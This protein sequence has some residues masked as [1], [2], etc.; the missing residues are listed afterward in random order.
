MGEKMKDLIKEYLEK[1]LN[2]I[3]IGYRLPGEIN[4]DQFWENLQ[5]AREQGAERIA[6]KDQKG[7]GF[8]FNVPHSL[9]RKLHEIDS[10]GRDTLFS[11][12]KAEI[13]SEM[14]KES[15]IE[16]ALNSSVIEGAFSTLKRA[17]ELA[18][19]NENPKDNSEQMIL[20]NFYAMRFILESIKRPF[21]KEIILELHKIV[22]EKTL[23]EKNRRIV[24][25]RKKVS[26]FLNKKKVATTDPVIGDVLVEVRKDLNV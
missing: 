5:K 2:K 9:Q 18:Y 20:N 19:K 3:E 13:A 14:I 7:K 12:V 8:W 17:R 15:L 10:D 25:A 6:L 22:T 26:G 23:E 21:S 1:Y 16:E 4:L 24:E 11:V